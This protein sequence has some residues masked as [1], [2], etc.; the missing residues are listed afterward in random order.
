MVNCKPCETPIDLKHRIDNDEEGATVD[1]YQRLVGKLIYLIRTRPD[2]AYVVTWW[3]NS[4]TTQKIH[5]CRQFIDY[6][7]I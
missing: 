7:N 5:I 2:V 6:S 1:Q 4:C 3:A